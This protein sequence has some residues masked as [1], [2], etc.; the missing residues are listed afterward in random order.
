MN[1]D[2]K[3]GN[4]GGTANLDSEDENKFGFELVEFVVLTG[5]P[6]EAAQAGY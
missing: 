5:H 2:R 3:Y 6:S 4:I 1:W